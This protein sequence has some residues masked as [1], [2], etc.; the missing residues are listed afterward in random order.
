MNDFKKDNRVYHK[1][2]CSKC[3]EE[4]QVPFEPEEGRDVFCKECYK[5]RS[6]Y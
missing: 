3:G 6:K 4:T 1:A 5:Q 2:V